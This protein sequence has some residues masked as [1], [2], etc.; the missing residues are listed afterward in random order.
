MELQKK[1]KCYQSERQKKEWQVLDKTVN[2]DKFEHASSS[3]L[4]VQQKILPNYVV[5]SD[6]SINPV[7][8]A[9]ETKH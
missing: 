7:N 4:L 3:E 2:R 5:V 6:I 8:I 9:T 1:N